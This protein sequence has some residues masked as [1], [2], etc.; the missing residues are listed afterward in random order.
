MSGRK[1]KLE[2]TKPKMVLVFMKLSR[3]SVTQQCYEFRHSMTRKFQRFRFSCW[4]SYRAHL[5]WLII[6]PRNINYNV[7]LSYTIQWPNGKTDL[8]LRRWNDH[9][10]EN[11]WNSLCLDDVCSE[12]VCFITVFFLDLGRRY[13]KRRSNHFAKVKSLKCSF[14]NQE[15]WRLSSYENM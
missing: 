5:I 3:N 11:L 9:C 14:L 7:M 10:Y 2:K 1:Y 8:Q 4:F 12:R 6:C 13:S 15:A